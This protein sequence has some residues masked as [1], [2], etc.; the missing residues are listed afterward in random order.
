MTRRWGRSPVG[1]RL[2]CP[3][4]HGHYRTTTLIAAVRLDGPRAPWLFDGPVAVAG[5]V[6]M[7]KIFG[8]V[9]V[10]AWPGMAL[11]QPVAVTNAVAATHAA[12][13]PLPSYAVNLNRGN[14][15]DKD[16]NVTG[17]LGPDAAFQTNWN[18]LHA[19]RRVDFGGGSFSRTITDSAGLRPLVVR[20]TGHNDWGNTGKGDDANDLTRL[21][22]TGG[23]DGGRAE[24]IKTET[25]PFPGLYDVYIYGGAGGR[26]CSVNGSPQQTF[27]T[28]Q[29]KD[30]FE[31]EGNFLVF[32][33][34]SGVMEMVL[35]D[36]LAGFSIVA[37]ATPYDSH[38]LPVGVILPDGFA[39]A[40]EILSI[41]DDRVGFRRSG[42]APESLL[43][44]KVAVIL[45]QSMS[46]RKAG[47]LKRTRPGLLLK[48]LDFLEGE[49]G[50]FAKG[51]ISMSSVL[52]G[53]HTFNVTDQAVALV[54]RP[55]A[56]P[57]S[58]I[59][60]SAGAALPK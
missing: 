43:L 47:M 10:V 25:A 32:P 45:F 46:D 44:S 37:Q 15:D 26:T 51:K 38:I 60:P 55:T 35:D 28:P 30:A 40:A 22:T 17:A 19:P 41:G 39:M 57:P 42:A 59:S 4:P 11:A 21:L 54:L 9:L 29:K 23:R 7:K 53:L 31:F 33:G 20:F 1:E 36:G 3:V 52:F 48:N 13:L 34:L 5:E 18:N 2:V 6:C 12:A 8:I 49:P 24:T 14:S 50:E 16:Y 58:A 27:K 56:R